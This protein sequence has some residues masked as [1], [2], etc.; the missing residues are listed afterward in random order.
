LTTTLIGGKAART[1]VLL[2]L[3]SSEQSHDGSESAAFRLQFHLISITKS[4]N[5]ATPAQFSALPFSLP[6]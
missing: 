6:F 4:L 3:F 1:E 5:V 2:E